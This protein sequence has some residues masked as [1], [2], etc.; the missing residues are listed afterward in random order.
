MAAEPWHQG[1]SKPAVYGV[2]TV[3]VSTFETILVVA[4]SM[5]VKVAGWQAVVELSGIH[6]RVRR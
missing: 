2:I 1:W 6:F 3:V 5:V 4:V